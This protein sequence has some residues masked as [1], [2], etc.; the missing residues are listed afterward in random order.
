VDRSVV[1]RLMQ[2]WSAN[3]YGQA[4]VTLVQL[5]GVPILL[6]FWGAQLYGEW[7]IISAL[8]FYLSM[9]DLGFSQSAAN[10][11][12]ARVARGDTSSALR[13]FQSL[14]ALVIPVAACGVIVVGV[15]A[16]LLPLGQWFH[17]SSLSTAD[18][19]WIVW[20]LAAEILVKLND[21]IN[22]AGFRASGDYAIHVTIYYS[23][24]LVQNASV[25]AVAIL[26]L[27]PVAAAVAFFSIRAVVTPSVAILLTRRHP[28][29]HFGFAYASR[30]HLRSLLRPALANVGVPLAQALNIQGMVLLVG[31]V[32]GPLAVVTFSTL[33][34]LTRFGF[35]LVSTVSQAAEPELAAAYGLGDRSL[36]RTLYEHGIRAAFW[37][38]LVIAAVL[39]FTGSWVLQFWTHGRV[40]MDYSLFYW[41]LASSVA[42]VLWYGSLI[43]LK[44]ANRHL[45]AALVYAGAAGTAL[46]LA[47][48]LL[49][50]SHSLASA[51]MSLLLMDVVM[52]TY[53]MRAAGKLSDSP[54][55][56]NLFAALNPLPLVR[57]IMQKRYAL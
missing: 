39:A 6:R 42:S 43:V 53:T 22:H 31:R 33:R 3:L 12:T 38:A 37:L 27:G 55:G 52:L 5:A 40:V 29:L 1:R 46:L 23:T 17:F 30:T 19:R 15:A 54:A 16:F 14:C 45:R 24:F 9:T 35:Q 32:A 34:T 2:G 57:L 28:W 20:L 11:M 10:D 36:L 18:V 41:L 4:V 7:L 50:R 25:W 8:P 48:V 13:V 56:G 49:G 47:A 26:G 44:A 51:G 21:G